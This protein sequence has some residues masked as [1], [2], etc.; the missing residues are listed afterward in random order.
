MQPLCRDRV[1]KDMDDKGFLCI[2]PFI[3]EFSNAQAL[4][5]A[6][7]I[8]L[9]AYL[10]Q[11]SATLSQLQQNFPTLEALEIL[12]QQLKAGN[13]LQLIAQDN[14][15][16]ATWQISPAFAQT[17]P[18]QDL[19][20]AKLELA[21]LVAPDLMQHYALFLTDMPAFIQQARIFELFAYNLSIE[22]TPENIAATRR[23]MR[24][25]T[26][27]TRHEGRLIARQNDLSHVRKHLDIG[28]NSGE[29]ALQ[30]CQHYPQ[31]NST[32]IDL[33]VVCE[34]GKQHL[35]AE[36]EF[37]RIRFCAADALAD[38]L[39]A[40]QDLVTFKSI[41]HDWPEEACAQFIRQATRA[42]KPGGEILICERGPMDLS[43]PVPY[44]LLPMLLFNRSFRAPETYI[45]LLQQAGFSAIKLT[46]IALETPFFQITARLK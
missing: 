31:L 11:Q 3:A 36:K 7:E 28:G 32:I 15:A 21:N 29:F 14:S 45:K 46:S 22:I 13:V 27:L 38:P 37:D 6:F 1:S 18:F 26:C 10:S 44:G 39:P 41:L 23:W 42:L 8:G 5:T 25:T 20:L 9:I 19:L 34:V 2:E 17:Q 16:N 30:L 35:S 4:K 12:L 40:G 24:F 33:P 43:Q